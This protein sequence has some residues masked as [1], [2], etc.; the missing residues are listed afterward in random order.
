MYAF[1]QHAHDAR[2]HPSRDA[3]VPSHN[4]SLAWCLC[5]ILGRAPRIALVGRR[6]TVSIWLEH[7]CEIAAGK[8][9]SLLPHAHPA[10]HREYPGDKTKDAHGNDELA[11]F[12]GCHPEHV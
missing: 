10:W 1:H 2:H 5:G 3:L 11:C 6:T 9:K 4:G 8:Q 7:G 12:V